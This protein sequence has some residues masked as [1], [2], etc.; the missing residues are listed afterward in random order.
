MPPTRGSYAKSAPA[1]AASSIMSP[2]CLP[3]RPPPPL[4]PRANLHDFS[5][6]PL[7]A[8]HEGTLYG[9]RRPRV[10]AAFLALYRS[11]KGSR[12]GILPRRLTPTL[13][14]I[15]GHRANGFL[16]GGTLVG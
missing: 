15:Q 1:P 5:A 14:G 8:L 7:T 12:H 6:S 10:H 2:M 11:G 9:P 4:H 16:E 3:G 13:R